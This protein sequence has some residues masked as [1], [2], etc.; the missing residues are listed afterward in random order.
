MRKFYTVVILLGLLSFPLMA[1]DNPKVEVFGGY[2]YLNIGSTNN[3]PSSSQGF[4]GWD[5]SAAFNFAK[6]LGVE[7]DFSGSYATIDGVSFKIYTYSGGPVVSAQAG[8]IKPF[9][10]VLIGG[11]H[12]SGSESSNSV[13]WNGYT[14]MAGGGLDAKV[15]RALAVRLVQADWVYYNLGSTT[16]AGIS[17]PG[18][19]GSKN[20]RIATGIVFRF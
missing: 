10:H 16:V 6:Y 20:V 1:Q 17:V 13:S 5:A 14:V 19:S 2:Q 11:I 8:R 7:G 4:N 18:F 15:N 12:L 3:G 9:A